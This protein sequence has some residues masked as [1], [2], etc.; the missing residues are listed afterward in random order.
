MG[1]LR[2]NRFLLPKAGL[3]L[4]ECEDTIAVNCHTFRFAIADGATEAFDSRRWAKYLT[5]SWVSDT[6]AGLE[7]LDLRKGLMG[8]GKRC[9]DRWSKRKLPWYAEEKARL[10]SFAAFLGLEIRIGPGSGGVWKALAVGDCCLM[11]E[12]E[13]GLLRS[14]PLTSAEQFGTRPTLVPS[15]VDDYPAFV[16]AVRLEEGVCVPGDVFL[17]MS[18]AISCW[19][20]GKVAENPLLKHEFHEVVRNQDKVGLERIVARERDL[21]DMRNDDVAILRIE[22][23]ATEAMS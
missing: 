15:S 10:G 11:L 23:K 9:A 4:S 14:F 12:R 22:I 8:L 2:I 7:P 5:V 20:L 6:T 17:G 3:R 16:D 19:Y 1:A 21:K 13:D 18:D